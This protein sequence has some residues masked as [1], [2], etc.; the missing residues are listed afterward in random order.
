MSTSAARELPR[1]EALDPAFRALLRPDS[2]FDLVANGMKFTEGPVWI[3]SKQELIWSDVRGNRM[4][5]W[6]KDR[7]V[8]VFRDPSDVSNGNTLDLEGR[9]L[10]CE[11]RARQVVRTDLDGTR[12]VVADS[13]NGGRLNSPNDVVVKSD[14]A[15]W[16][17]DPDYGLVAP[18]VGS[19]VH[20]EQ[21]GNYV[22]RLDPVS[23]ALTVVA[24]DFD[25]PNGLAFSPDESKLYIADSGRTHRPDAPHHIRVFDVID[26]DHLANGRLFAKI[27]P[28]IPD[29]M[30]VAPDGKVFTTA[31]DGVQVFSPDARLLGKFLTPEVAANC[32]FG[33]PDG[34]VL[35]ICA[36]SSV[37]AIQLAKPM[38]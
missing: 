16:F 32:A 20:R 30:R 26:G 12:R 6:H 9:L 22:F 37:W 21:P 14:G 33:G 1:F 7:G 36:S 17:T 10:T 2:R 13:Y 4:Y 38:R 31:G 25:K 8:S 18:D 23:G 24:D 27:E 29:G 3:A 11:M 28:H 35:Y 5:R 19:G 34:D 15:I